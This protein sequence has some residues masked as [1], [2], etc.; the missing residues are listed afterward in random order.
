MVL[1]QISAPLFWGF[2][3]DVDIN[4]VSSVDHIINL[5]IEELKRS[6]LKL[7]LIEQIEILENRHQTI[8]YNFNF[9]IYDLTFDDIKKGVKIIYICS[10]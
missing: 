3:Y 2:Y 8:N 9:H 7:N 6:L 1:C 10:H 5:V 4:K